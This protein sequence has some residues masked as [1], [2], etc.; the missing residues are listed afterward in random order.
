MRDA[1]ARAYCSRTDGRRHTRFGV[2]GPASRPAGV[3]NNFVE[4][5]KCL[6]TMRPMPGQV[7]SSRLEGSPA[8]WDAGNRCPITMVSTRSGTP[9]RP[10]E[11]H[12][13]RSVDAVRRSHRVG[14]GL[15]IASAGKLRS[16]GFGLGRV[17]DRASSLAQQP[18]PS[19]VSLG[20]TRAVATQRLSWHMSSADTTQGPPILG[21]RGRCARGLGDASSSA[22]GVRAVRL[23]LTLPC[24]N[25]LLR[26]ARLPVPPRP[27]HSVTFTRAEPNA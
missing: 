6:L 9:L 24:E 1:G 8:R 19:S 22:G 23:E 26:P 3:N 21:Q 10:R 2:G 25:G 18:L 5:G 20:R 27:L 12:R 14:T 17:E 4:L 16:S 15:P 11:H 7:R 13:C